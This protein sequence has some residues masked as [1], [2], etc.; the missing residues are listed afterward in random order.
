MTGESLA[1]QYECSFHETTAADDYRSVELVFHSITRDIAR[2]SERLMPLQPL[3]ISEDKSGLLN[4]VGSQALTHRTSF[5]R[6][7]SPKSQDVKDSKKDD[8]D[9]KVMTRRTTSTFR[10][11]NKSFKIFN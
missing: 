6:A 10:I 7:K 3:F 4:P 2:V 11:F 9:A 5:R 1:R 8:K